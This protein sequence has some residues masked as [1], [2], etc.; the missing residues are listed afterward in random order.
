MTHSDESVSRSGSDT[1]VLCTEEASIQRLPLT[2]QED[3]ATIIHLPGQKAGIYRVRAWLDASSYD[4]KQLYLPMSRFNNQGQIT[5]PWDFDFERIEP[6]IPAW[7]VRINRK[8]VGMVAVSRPSPSQVAGRTMSL[9]WCYDLRLAGDVTIELRPFNDTQG[10][11]ALQWHIEREQQDVIT[12][13]TP[14]Q[15][16]LEQASP[17]KAQVQAQVWR[18]WED[19]LTR[20]DPRYAQVLARGIDQAKAVADQSQ[21]PELL[22]LL[23]YAWRA[24]KDTQAFTLACQIVQSKIGQEHWGNPCESGYGHDGDMA[25]AAIIETLSHAWHWLGEDMDRHA[26][27]LHRRLREKL[28]LQMERFFDKALLWVNYWGGSHMQD[29]GHRSIS[30]FG[31]AAA[32]MLGVLDDAPRWFAFAHQRISR[33]VSLLPADGG[34][35]LSSYFKIHLYMDDLL[36]WRDACLHVTGQD[37]YD[38]PLFARTLPCVINRLDAGQRIVMTCLA[39]GDRK[40]FYAGWG[41]F[42][43]IA[44]RTK[45]GQGVTLTHL[46]L[47]DYL[48]RPLPL[49]P[50]ATMTD[51]LR[52]AS[53]D[54]QPTPLEPA[55]FD[56]L[57]DIGQVNYR[58]TRE[59]INVAMRCMIPAGQAASFKL[60]NP[61]DRIID[62][63]MEGH[64]SVHIKGRNLLLTAE[65]GYQMRSDLSSALIIDGQGGYED[66]HYA[67]GVPGVTWRGQQIEIARY[68][69]QTRT[70]LVR[71]NLGPAYPREAGILSYVR[72]FHLTPSSLRLRD[73]LVST[74]PHQYAWHFHSYSSVTQRMLHENHWQISQEDASLELTGLCAESALQSS[75]HATPVVWAYGNEHHDQTFKHVRFNTLHASACL[76]AEFVVNW[77][78]P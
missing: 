9:V 75:T 31:A 44:A 48:K 46:L 13:T 35:P 27:T 24:R 55:A 1:L 20:L 64:F 61:C 43:A 60:T 72:E 76:S 4:W 12:P 54:L 2:R 47:D 15:A 14:R 50:L 67:M 7:W 33:V 22:K 41:F 57:P 11:H 73:L 42:N 58:Q 49:R 39:R 18:E 69:P 68:D 3:G 70:A 65:G 37:I 38:N 63:P 32:N 34:I 40:D 74:R 8:A 6:L 19:K 36:S 30:R 16:T 23:C 29:H 71:M 59:N 10:L 45:Q 28:Q 56:H 17:A 51:M 62:A 26:P 25:V 66:Q 21:D 5:G 52:H 77:A 53:P 78:S